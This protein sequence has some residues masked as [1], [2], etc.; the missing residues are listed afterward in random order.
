MLRCARF[1]P[2]TRPTRGS[3][4]GRSRPHSWAVKG[5]TSLTLQLLEAEKTSW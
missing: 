5:T 4:G 1:S 3:R 2:S